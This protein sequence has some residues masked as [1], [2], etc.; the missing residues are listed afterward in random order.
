MAALGATAFILGIIGFIIQLGSY[1][2]SWRIGLEPGRETVASALQ[3]GFVAALPVL[4]VTIG[5]IIVIGIIFGAL[6]GGAM[7]PMLMGGSTPT[8]GAALGALG[9]MGL[10]MPLFFVI[11]LWL[12]A[13]LCVMGP[14]MAA[15]RSF[16]PLTAIAES[17]RMTAAS[18]WKLMGYF[19]LLGIVFFVL[20]MILGL[21]FGV[22]MLAGGAPGSGSIILLTIMS[23][24]IG[25]PM[26][27]LYVGIPAGIYRALGGDQAGDVFA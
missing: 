15:N 27:Y 8:D 9:M 18:Q 22:S 11:F 1:Y 5:F 7:L 17:W 24:L 14:V 6:F 21:V 16:N 4:L 23:A 12:S 3:Y 13:R 10:A 19:I 25:I 2:A 20:A 26:A